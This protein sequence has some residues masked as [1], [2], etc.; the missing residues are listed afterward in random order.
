MENGGEGVANDMSGTK[1]RFGGGGG[2]GSY[3][4]RAAVALGT[5][6][7]LVLRLK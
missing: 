4:Q 2:K 7:M 6:V 3:V 5:M 1:W